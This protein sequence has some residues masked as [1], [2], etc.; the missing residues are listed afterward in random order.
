M[1]EE[2]K[3]APPGH[4]NK[5]ACILNWLKVVDDWSIAGLKNKLPRLYYIVGG[6]VVLLIVL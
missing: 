6:L 4:C 5:M 1:T 2:S 3:A